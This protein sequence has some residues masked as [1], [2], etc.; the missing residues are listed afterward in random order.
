MVA[1]GTGAAGVGAGACVAADAGSP[2]TA[3][4]KV[5]SVLLTTAGWVGKG[6]RG[7]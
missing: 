3:T 7:V 4:G 2:E 1:S 6:W 5:P